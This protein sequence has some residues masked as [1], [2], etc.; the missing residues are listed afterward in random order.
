MSWAGA[1]RVNVER[2]LQRL[3]IEAKKRGREWEAL[4]PNP[5]HADRSPSWRIRDEPGHT[6]HGYHHCWPC[7][8]GGTIVDLVQAK[9]G[10]AS[11][12]DALKWLEEG[13]VD[14]RP[15][16]TIEVRV[17]P[18]SLRFRLPDEVRF[19]PLAEWPGPARTYLEGRGI[20][21][22]QVARWGI[23]YAVEGRLKGRVVFVLRDAKGRPQGYSARTFLKDPDAKRFLEPEEHERANPSAMFGEQFW[24]PVSARAGIPVFVF[25]G[26]IKA[27]AASAALDGI[28]VGATTGSEVRPLHDTKLATFGAQC[29]VGDDDDAGDKVSSQLL[30][31]LA[32]HGRATRLRLPRGLD[33][34]E[35]PRDELRGILLDWLRTRR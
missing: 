6:R 10:L 25:E 24:P 18:P 4:C 34:D 19:G 12:K 29:I 1:E 30:A 26:A 11:Y 20:D 35:L 8:F 31:K 17:R 2:V 14:Q 22:C 21:A 28:Y 7:G 27:L 3:G 23:G 5:E 33:A 15:V 32:R 9:L 13:A 16:E